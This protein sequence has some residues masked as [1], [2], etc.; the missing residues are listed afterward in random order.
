MA[1]EQVVEIVLLHSQ[2]FLRTVSYVY[3]YVDDDK[4]TPKTQ[5]MSRVYIINLW[6]Y[7]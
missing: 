2:Q 1:V 6:F 4:I 3:L 5:Q 7:V